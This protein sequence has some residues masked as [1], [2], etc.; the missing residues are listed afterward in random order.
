[1]SK[2]LK[3]NG[4]VIGILGCLVMG[5]FSW[6]YFQ[7]KNLQNDLT[8]QAQKT[9]QQAA[10]NVQKPTNTK[11][12]T[13]SPSSGGA[14][15]ANS[16]DVITLNPDPASDQTSGASRSNPTD[17]MSRGTSGGLANPASSPPVNYKVKM[18]SVYNDTL[19]AMLS[20]KANTLALQGHK[21]SLAQ[22][23]ASISQAKGTFTK[24]QSYTES[25][26]PSD[27]KVSPYYQDFLSGIIIAN[28]SMDVVLNGIS[29][30][31]PSSL[32]TARDMGKSA[33][34]KVINAYKNF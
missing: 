21:I 24:A 9:A 12:T 7:S 26:P 33:Q 15:G 27:S 28:Q 4:L 17:S 11:N 19:A 5:F 16:T 22:Y 2:S 10:E 23:K 20:V 8:A 6:Q 3:R 34:Q 18:A 1:M 25:N 32:Y 30:L 29:S 13:S 31:N 14:T